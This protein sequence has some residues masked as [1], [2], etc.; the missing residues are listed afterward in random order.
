MAEGNGAHRVNRIR[1]RNILG[2]EELDIRPGKV[3]VIEGA[4][5]SGKTSALEALKAVFKGGHDA[6]LIRRGAKEGEV[7]LEIGPDDVEV[8]KKVRPLTSSLEA[9]HPT[10]G[11]ISASQTWLNGLVDALSVN[12]IE[13]LVASDRARKL[14][15]AMPLELPRERLQ[16]AMEG[17]GLEAPAPSGRVHALELIDSARKIVYDERTGVNRVAKEQRTTAE[18]LR[19]SLPAGAGEADQANHVGALERRQKDLERKLAGEVSRI[20]VEVEKQV[21]RV[22]AQ[23]AEVTGDLKDR[24]RDAEREAEEEIA[25]IR[26]RLQATK[27]RINAEIES[28]EHEAETQVEQLRADAVSSKEDLQIEVQPEINKLEAAIGAARERAKAAERDANTRRMVEEARAKAEAH[29]AKSRVLTSALERLDA[30]KGG[31]LEALPIEGVTIQ[32]GEVHRY[33]IPFPRLNT[34]E[35]IKLCVEVAKLRAGKLSLVCVDGLERLDD[36]TFDLF[37]Q[38]LVSSGLEAVVTRVTEGPLK[39]T[40]FG[41]E[42]VG[43]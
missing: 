15:E 30:L 31:L 2:I 37:V 40:A 14:L 42:V 17:T 5:A 28:L 35:Q 6:T 25:R 19:A 26:E 7:V 9:R 34:A 12:P 1:I 38:E 39:V 11:K 43:V 29:E 24:I 16:E 21:S 8:T 13:F 20:D 41:E 18:Q 3:T 33:G 27:E 10:M 4:N 32:D 22:N 23:L 36:P